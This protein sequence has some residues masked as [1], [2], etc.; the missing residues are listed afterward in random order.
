LS[1]EPIDEAH[2]EQQ[3]FA[4][5]A[6]AALGNF[7]GP[8]VQAVLTRL[9]GAPEPVANT[10]VIALAKALKADPDRFFRLTSESSFKTPPARRAWAQALGELGGPRA[11]LELK[12]ILVRVT[13]ERADPE[14]ML[15]LPMILA[16]LKKTQAPDFQE[17]LLP[18][19][20]SHDGVVLRVAAAAYMPKNGAKTPWAPIVRAYEHLAPGSDLEAKVAVLKRL[21]PWI[22]ETGIEA[23]LRHA[24][25]D[26]Q[27]N[28]RIAAM[29]LL[30]MTAATDV[31]ENPGPSE[32]DTTDVTYTM[33]AA[34][35]KDRTVAAMETT[36]GTLEIELFREDAPLTVANFVLLAKQGFFNGLSF[37]R[38]V[39][40]FVVQGG[41]PRNDQEGGPGY[42][43]RCEINLRSYGRGSIGMALAGKDTGGSQFFI[44]LAP[45]PHLD[46]GYTC[47]GRVISG[48]EALDRIVP[49]DR[50]NKISI[51]ED[52]T[53]I[54]Y[55][56]Y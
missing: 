32:T 13:D 51:S 35:R 12:S 19:L 4:V 10:A 15:V 40:S 26:R 41:D 45:Q 48:M 46:G 20:D 9:L 53:A 39:P 21:E 16:S 3:N 25:K 38:V 33:L 44:T 18:F 2:P 1:G 28:V 23:T 29:R 11:I 5:Q 37:M 47:F 34:A 6:A 52:V 43:I 14:G 22:R 24:L 7:G 42:T 17:I 55:R 56:R 31:P 54:D 27:R 8:E 50:I 49:G 30:R 36:R